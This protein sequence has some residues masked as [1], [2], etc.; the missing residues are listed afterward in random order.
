MAK[1]KNARS[2]RK[3]EPGDIVDVIAPASTS[4]RE[5]F[6]KAPAAIR[7]MGLES[8]IPKRMYS[9]DSPFSSNSD[10]NRAAMLIKALR[11]KDSKL[12]WCTRGGYGCARLLPFLEKI[13]PPKQPKLLMGYSDIT[14]L[15]VFL[16]DRWGWSTLHGPVL[17]R[18]SS[19]KLPKE[20]YQ[21]LNN[22]L[23][24]AE[25]QIQYS[26]LK[27]L[28]ARARRVKRVSGRV[29][30]GNLTVYMTLFGTRFEP[31]SPQILMLEDIGE[32][33]YQLDRLLNQL[34]QSE[35]LKSVKAIVFGEFV[36]GQE[37]GTKKSFVHRAIQDFA[38]SCS[39]PVFRWLKFGH[40]VHNRP[41]P[42]GQ[43]GVL[44]VEKKGVTLTVQ[45]GVASR[46]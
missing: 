34:T 28:N 11:A 6:R 46:A 35:H 17:D 33:G 43:Q 19:G 14:A 24:G 29:G 37:P 9:K 36:G 30:G 15:H 10:Q 5:L 22:I 32:R 40:G 38:E 20:D 44:K 1:G 8:R 45:T 7:G 26:G 31:T 41:M 13:K 42:F 12:I 25:G 39:L 16:R 27:Q 18:L 4:P 21:A 2:W 3:L 23:F